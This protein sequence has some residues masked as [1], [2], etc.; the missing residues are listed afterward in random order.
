MQLH[1]IQ[2]NTKRK[3]KKTVG[4]GGTRGKTSGRGHKGQKARSGNS[5][6]PAIR[7]VIKSIPKRRGYGVNR[8]RTINPNKKKPTG[9]TLTRIDEFFSNGESV[10]RELLLE[11]NLVRA[12]RGR[13]PIVKILGTGEITKKITVVDCEYT[14]IAGEKIVKAGGTLPV[15]K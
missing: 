1:E 5:T 3:T 2:S 4:R 7:D 14:K 10:T 11:R 15:Q 13:A 6:R 12:Y 9:V 8:S